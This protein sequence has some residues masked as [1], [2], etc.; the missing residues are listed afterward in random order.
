MG[1]QYIWMDTPYHP[2]HPFGQGNY[3]L[4]C[5]LR[6]STIEA[7]FIKLGRAL[8]TGKIFIL[9]SGPH[10]DVSEPVQLIAVEWLS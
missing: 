7:I 6:K 4:V 2:T 10:A 3:E 8:V 1:G 9:F 5:R